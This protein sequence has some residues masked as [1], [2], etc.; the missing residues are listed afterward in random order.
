MFN[1]VHS[2]HGHTLLLITKPSLQATALLQHL[3][4]SLAITGKLHN[5]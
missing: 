5:I 4:Q 1:E 2:S 3:K